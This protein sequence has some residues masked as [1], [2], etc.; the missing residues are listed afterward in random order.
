ML[1]GAAWMQS[2]VASRIAED[3]RGAD[4]LQE[5]QAYLKSPLEP[6]DTLSDAAVIK[7]WRDHKVVYPTLA[8][9]ARDFLAIPGSSSA[10]E[11]QFS[12]ARQIGTDT[13]NRL[14]P[15]MF[16]AVQTL[17]GGYKSGI[18]SAQ[19]EASALAEELQCSIDDLTPG[20]CDNPV[21]VQ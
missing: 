13:R 15:D 1:Y 14:S 16:Q 19:L 20:S 21:V 18:I 12:S 2:A 4:P 11:R 7:W 3:A 5:L 9:M 17:K 8:R 6:F 10:S